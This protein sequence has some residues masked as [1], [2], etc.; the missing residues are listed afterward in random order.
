[1]V[2][3][4]VR[5]AATAQYRDRT[6]AAT[7]PRPCDAAMHV[8][9]CMYMCMY[10]CMY[11]YVCICVCAYVY[12]RAMR[13]CP[14]V[15]VLH[16]TCACAARPVPQ[17]VCFGL[18]ANAPARRRVVE[19]AALALWNAGAPHAVMEFKSAAPPALSRSC[20]ALTDAP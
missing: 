16:L 6:A 3:V 1:V 11:M 9:V 12:V 20:V 17:L 18:E 13:R 15:A 14:R 8:Y 7:A 4:V 5:A 19:A 2:V 10:I